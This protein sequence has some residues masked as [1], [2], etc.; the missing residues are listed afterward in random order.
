MIAAKVR[1]NLSLLRDNFLARLVNG[2]FAVN[3][4]TL[5]RASSLELRL[6][7]GSFTVALIVQDGGQQDRKGP[8]GDESDNLFRAAVMSRLEQ[9][10]PKESVYCFNLPAGIGFLSCAPQPDPGA[11]FGQLDDLIAWINSEAS[12]NLTIIAAREC[13]R[14]E[15]IPKAFKAVAQALDYKM[16]MGSNQVIHAEQFAKE[17]QREETAPINFYGFL[18]GFEKELLL[19]LKNDNQPTV[20]S[21]IGQICD[22]AE[23]SVAQK[24]NVP[25]LLAFF[26]YQLQMELGIYADSP[27][28]EAEDIYREIR[29]VG[30]LPELQEYLTSFFHD[31]RQDIEKR[32]QNQRNYLVDRAVKYIEQNLH[33][34]ISLVDAAD[35]LRI[36][37]SYL[38][39]IFKSVTDKSFTDYVSQAKMEEAKRLL[40]T[41]AMRVYE[42]SE[43][44]DYHDPGY[45]I[46]LFKKVYGVS[47]GEYR[48]L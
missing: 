20:D 2:K 8:D 27:P 48:Q 26:L 25:F 38:S 45:F 21:F 46:K 43:L 33:E 41:T 36:H 40:Q 5:A 3:G 37:P 23:T 15:D 6:E 32:N 34:Q 47:P 4:E 13:R 35:R 10:F 30:S 12:F 22:M 28:M 17:I 42:I 19:A 29:E 14:P 18:H 44:L 7:G 39:K 31:I 16:I 9:V 24:Q 1:E 11:V